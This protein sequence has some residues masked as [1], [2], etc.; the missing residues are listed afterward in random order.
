V[1]DEKKD[2]NHTTKWAG[3]HLGRQFLVILRRNK[4]K[5]T[6][7]ISLFCKEITD[8]RALI[9]HHHRHGSNKVEATGEECNGKRN[10]IITKSENKNTSTAISRCHN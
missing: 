5:I 9:Q 8:Y 1:N 3:G 2:D 6:G 10:K 4:T 7:R